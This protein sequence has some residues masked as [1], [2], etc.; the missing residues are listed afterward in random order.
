M[1]RS[2]AAPM[3]PASMSAKSR[4]SGPNASG[5][6]DSRLSTPQ[7][8]PA[9]RIG[10]ASSE[11]APDV[12][13]R[14][15]EEVGV[16]AGVGDEHRLA[17]ARGAAVDARVERLLP[18]RA[19]RAPSRRSARRRRRDGRSTS[20]GS[21]RCMTTRNQPN[22]ACSSSTVAR[23]TLAGSSSGASAPTGGARGQPLALARGVGAAARGRGRLAGRVDRPA[24]RRRVDVALHRVEVHVRRGEQRV[25]GRAGVGPRGHAGRRR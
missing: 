6:R 18:V 7:I 13:A 14:G 9:T 5:S 20:S 17:G 1:L 3:W 11:R 25:L 4:S 19:S 21:R 12:A 23:A 8:S 10:T 16:A 15:V 22:V 2:S 24:A